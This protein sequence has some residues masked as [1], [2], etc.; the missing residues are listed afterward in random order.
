MATQTWIASTVGDWFTA[1]NWTSDIV[2]E[3]GDTV[4][5]ASGTPRIPA[6]SVLGE[7][8]TLGG[9]IAGSTV[10][11]QAT[12]TTFG[13]AFI[14]SL[15]VDETLTMMGGDPSSRVTGTLFSQGITAFEGRI[16]FSKFAMADLASGPCKL[17]S[18]TWLD[19]C[20]AGAT[21]HGS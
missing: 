11:L 20:R 13:P 9:S 18:W 3:A 8:I 21:H 15:T 6:G 5:I 14:S 2:A 16:G 1:A 7:Q 17:T 19:R 4:I 12:S 10:T